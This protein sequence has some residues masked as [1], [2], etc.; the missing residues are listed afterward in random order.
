MSKSKELELLSSTE[1]T[2][3]LLP[4][5]YG[6]RM[7]P[8]QKLF[9]ESTNKQ[10]FICSANQIG[11]SSIQIKK[12]IQWATSPQYW[13]NLWPAWANTPRQFWY[14]YPSSGVAT[15]EFEKKWVPEFLPRGKMKDDPVYGWTD[16]YKAGFIQACHFKTGVTIYFKTYSQNTQDLQT[17]TAHYIGFDEELPESLYSEIQLRLVH[18]EGYLSGVFTPTLG[19]EFWREAIE[20]R[21]Y[22]ERFPDALKLQVSMYDC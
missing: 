20:V 16:E 15:V 12:M 17:S 3:S 11:K 6:Q 5:L 1:E 10:I 19:Q 21:G 8:W 14:L 7:Y 2:T 13:K 22:K 18:S 4:H 9:A